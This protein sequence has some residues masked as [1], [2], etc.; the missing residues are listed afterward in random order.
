M[1][2]D[3]SMITASGRGIMR[4][5]SNAR[6]PRDAFS[7]LELLCVIACISTAT[8]LAL[9]AI[10]AARESSRTA[11]CASNL[12]QI[13]T[14]H[15]GH[16]ARHRAGMSASDWRRNVLV[17]MEDNR[18]S[19]LCP[20]DARTDLFDINDYAVYIVNN[21]RT[22]PLEPGPWCAIGDTAF[23]EQFSGIKLPTPDSFFMV[24]EDMAYNS[25]F[26]GM[27]LAQ[28][29]PQGSWKLSHV[30]SNPHSYRHQLRDPLG[31]IIADPFAKGFT[32]TVQGIPTSYGM[33][34]RSARFTTDPYKVLVVEYATPV[35]DLVGP[36][37]S[38]VVSWWRDVGS[39]HRGL[40]NVL[41]GDGRVA[42][43]H[44]TEIDPT[45][46]TIHDELWCPTIDEKL[47]LAPR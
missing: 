42:R 24:Y 21:R 45:S 8:S 37:A 26:D 40:V 39:R 11:S 9:P 3:T 27:I 46:P 12:R 10:Q 38:G 41:Y 2:T 20:T 22:I 4:R 6:P 13:G 15:A 28:P 35:A 32:W 36:T 29:L 17:G 44:P 30:G 25:P 1:A 14:A 47:L 43:V 7:L 5:T 33:N 34:A 31:A 23:C 19:L 18:A 16:V